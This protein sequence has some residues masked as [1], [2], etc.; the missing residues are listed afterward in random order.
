MDRTSKEAFVAEFNEKLNRA[1]LAI[2]TDF[3]GIDVNSM[4]E[5]RKSLTQVE[6]AEYKVVKNR[7]ARRALEGTDFEGLS[8]FLDG[9]N[10]LLLSYGDVVEAAKALTEFMKDHEDMEVKGASLDG[11]MITEAQIEALADLPSKEVLQAMLL[12]VLQAPSRNFVSLLAN[13]NRQ[14]VNV[15]SAYRDKLEES[16]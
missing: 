6:G 2:V 12:G 7:L 8:E 11:A 1:Q 3:R 4:V 15:L 9:P 5:F 16:A 13:A 10:G 14:I